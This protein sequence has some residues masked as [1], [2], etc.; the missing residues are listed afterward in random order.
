ML[1]SGSPVT[2]GGRRL[3]D[4]RHVILG[5]DAVD[6]ALAAREHVI[7]QVAQ[8][9]VLLAHADRDVECERQPVVGADGERP[10]S[11]IGR[12]TV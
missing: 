10:R 2:P 9:A 6:V 3:G 12:R 4:P 5:E 11:P 1:Q 7:E 8:G